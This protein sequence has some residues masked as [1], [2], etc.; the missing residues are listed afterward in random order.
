MSSKNFIPIYKPVKS[1]MS[2][3]EFEPKQEIPGDAA[4]RSVIL[5]DL[6]GDAKPDMI[7]CNENSNTIF[8]YRNTGLNGIV[9][10]AS[11]E[12]KVSFETGAQSSSV[13]FA[14]L[15][16]DGRAEIVVTNYLSG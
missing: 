5:C 4:S 1:S 9:T 13:A 2:A 7:V 15:D 16:R 3:A 6:D 14:D 10:S 12:A 8:V 11:F